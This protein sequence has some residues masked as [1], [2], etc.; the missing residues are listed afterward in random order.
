MGAT[1]RPRTPGSASACRSLGAH[2]PHQLPPRPQPD[3]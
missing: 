1:A 2:P 3:L